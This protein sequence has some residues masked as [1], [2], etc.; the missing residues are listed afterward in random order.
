[1]ET[2]FNLRLATFLFSWSFPH[3]FNDKLWVNKQTTLVYRWCGDYSRLPITRTF[4]NSNQNR[5]PL[6]FH[7]TFTVIFP[8]VTWTLDNLNL[9][10]TQTNFHFPAGSF[11]YNFTL[12]N[13]NQYFS[14]KHWIYF[15]RGNLCILCPFLHLAPSLLLLLCIVS[16]YITFLINNLEILFHFHSTSLLLNLIAK[17]TLWIEIHSKHPFFSFSG[18]L[19]SIPYNSNLFLF[20]LEVQVIGSRLY[21]H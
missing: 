1:M 21:I 2:F 9:P 13:S 5:F 10:L 16:C 15:N 6:D 19:F 20:P 14:P 3:C 4:A 8:S 12:D 17:Y 7:H 11:L 18:H